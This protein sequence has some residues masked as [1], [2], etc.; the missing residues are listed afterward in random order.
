MKIFY[1]FIVL[2]SL[3]GVFGVYN[4][5]SAP[6]IEGQ[7]PP[8]V[9]LP[10]TFTFYEDF[11]LDVQLN[12]R[13]YIKD[14]ETPPS[15]IKW[16]FANNNH[17][18]PK[19]NTTTNILTLSA[20]PDWHGEEILVFIATD[21]DGMSSRDSTVVKVISCHDIRMGTID[22]DK[23]SSRTIYL[24]EYL[25]MG[26]L[27][28]IEDIK[29]DAAPSEYVDIIID[30]DTHEATLTPRK[31]FHG[32]DYI[33]FQA[34]L[35]LN[36]HQK[37][38][39]TETAK[40][41]VKDIPNIQPPHVSTIDS[42]YIYE[43]LYGSVNLRRYVSDDRDAPSTIKWS[44]IENGKHVKSHI[45]KS[46]VLIITPDKDWYGD[47]KIM[48]RATDSDSLTSNNTSVFVRIIPVFDLSFKQCTISSSDTTINLFE[49]VS[50]PLP[51][52]YKWEYSGGEKIKVTI[53]DSLVTLEPEKGFLMG[54]VN[55]SLTDLEKNIKQTGRMDIKTVSESPRFV[56]SFS[57]SLTVLQTIPRTLNLL[58]LATD[59]RDS[60]SNI[61]WESGQPGEVRIKI[62]NNEHTMTLSCLDS[63]WHGSTNTV[64]FTIKDSDGNK[65]KENF[66]IVVEPVHKLNFGEK[67]IDE[68]SKTVLTLAD[69]IDHVRSTLEEIEWSVTSGKH[70]NAGILLNSTKDAQ[71]VIVP[72]KGFQESLTEPFQDALVFTAVDIV[73]KVSV[74]DTLTVFIKGLPEEPP[75]LTLPKN[76]TVFEDSS[77]V[78]VR[79]QLVWDREDSTQ[80]INLKFYNNSNLKFEDFKDLDSLKITPKPDWH[81]TETV[82]VTATDS[83]GLTDSDSLTV[84]VIDTPDFLFYELNKRFLSLPEDS[85]YVMSDFLKYEHPER[86]IITVKEN[87][88]NLNIRVLSKPWKICF[89]P[90]PDSSAA[91]MAYFTAIDTLYKIPYLDSVYVKI[92]HT[93]D[94]P[95]FILPD[96]TITFPEDT[97]II[98][99]VAPKSLIDFVSDSD[100]PLNVMKFDTK[101]SEHINATIETSEDNRVIVELVPVHNWNGTEELVISVSDSSGKAV[102]DT[103]RI[104][105]LPVN[106]LPDSARLVYPENGINVNQATIDLRWTK[107]KDIDTYVPVSYYLITGSDIFLA[108]GDTVFAGQD[109][110]LTKS[111]ISNTRVF[112]RVLTVSEKDTIRSSVQY[113][114]TYFTPYFQKNGDTLSVLSPSSDVIDSTQT[115]KFIVKKLTMPDT[116]RDSNVLYTVY[117][118]PDSS[119]SHSVYFSSA[120][121]TD[122][123]NVTI[124]FP[125][126]LWNSFYKY[127]KKYYWEAIGVDEIYKK[128]YWLEKSP[129]IFTIGHAPLPITVLSP[130]DTTFFKNTSVT[131]QWKKTTDPDPNDTINYHVETSED[132][133]FKINLKTY[134]P[135]DISREIISC[136]INDFTKGMS[137][138]WQIV[139]EGGGLKTCS[140]TLKISFFVPE[141]DFK[142]T[143]PLPDSSYDITTFAAF[144]WKPPEGKDKSWQYKFF[145]SD[146]ESYKKNLFTTDTAMTSVIVDTTILNQKINTWMYCK[147]E[148]YNL[149]NFDL[150]KTDPDSFRVGNSPEK[151]KLLSPSQDIVVHEMSISLK[152]EPAVDI[153]NNDNI[154]SYVAEIFNTEIPKEKQVIDVGNKNECVFSDS[155]KD[156]TVYKCFVR[157]VDTIGLS[158]STDTV[159]VR[160]NTFSLRKPV[161]NAILQN[162]QPVF[163]WDHFYAGFSKIADYYELV[164]STDA[165]FS[166]LNTKTKNT[167]KNKFSFLEEDESLEPNNFWYWK[168]AA[169]VGNQRFWA[170]NTDKNPWKFIIGGDRL[171]CGFSNYPNP[172]I[173][174]TN[175]IIQFLDEINQASLSIYTTSGMLVFRQ[176]FSGSEFT[177]RDRNEIKWNGRDSRGVQ[178]SYGVYFAVLRAENKGK[179]DSAY[180]KIAIYPYNF[181]AKK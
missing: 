118:S 5:F 8:E 154:I 84:T 136:T 1:V 53:S 28:R 68:D 14:D 23:N 135:K 22:L 126:S 129:K 91:G 116:Q 35:N 145:L 142:I 13:N 172:F 100:T 95:V 103:I 122:Q 52:Y 180:R 36:N 25:V 26:E 130:A 94:S 139:A 143:N 33:T 147:V 153:D 99:P 16:N 2:I 105:I 119:F 167:E 42:V 152:W 120:G 159:S 11:S 112:W 59:D 133:L 109:T 67:T 181:G 21:Q 160:I 88:D 40:I 83:D 127:N 48:I 125:D 168:V 85:S 72:E 41:I 19:I 39:V 166:D 54:F 104:S 66:P 70:V 90:T 111:L 60:P 173:N 30:N 18:I 17:I 45:D 32:T 79:S 62:D 174:N 164:Y 178:L 4:A 170:S 7:F 27:G 162:S 137:Y 113:F 108:H 6:V 3:I 64:E 20:E 47:D 49:F 179:T 156:N 117:M 77:I 141:G 76:V 15:L 87:I 82:F 43:D 31:D 150:C 177:S 81:G 50:P 74:T 124:Q 134:E 93:D 96:S 38:T 46:N 98:Y 169:I 34:T 37:I 148:A 102:S 158:T 97:S 73:T 114:T 44:I 78:L 163:E 144:S 9:S 71:V 140:D 138:Y 92:F 51:R 110:T 80:N 146:D 58:E 55:F 10:D 69:Y 171:I 61:V 29:W 149:K 75:V 165:T 89:I 151:F 161:N 115:G 106:D 56:S 12:S 132:S 101:G 65:Y 128:T 86:V 131:F 57:E 63:N 24:D 155:L 123:P 157:A 121:P 176:D 175:F 107:C